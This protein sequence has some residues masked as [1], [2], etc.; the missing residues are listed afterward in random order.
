MQ[1]SLPPL[2]LACLAIAPFG[3]ASA[4]AQ[5]PDNEPIVLDPVL[6]NA[7]RITQLGSEN[8]S[9]NDFRLNPSNPKNRANLDLS[10]TLEDYSSYSSYRRTRSYTAHPTTQGVRIRN[11]GATATSRALVLYDGVPQNDPFGGW[12]YWHQYNTAQ[13]G[14]VLFSPNGSGASWGNL[15]A[16]GLVSIISNNPLHGSSTVDFSV[17][18]S[19]T[20]ILNATST[21]AINETSLIDLQ[22]R[23][24]SSDGFYTLREDQRGTVDQRASSDGYALSTRL[25]LAPTEDWNVQLSAKAFSEERGNGTAV[26]QNET[27]A[28]NLSL[29]AEHSID[30]DSRLNIA[31]Y[32]QDRDFQNVFAAVAAERNSERP[33]LDQYDVPANAYGGAI[34]YTKQFDENSDYSVG[35]DYRAT[36]GSVNERYRNLGAGFSRHRHAGGKQ[37]FAGAFAKVAT[38]FGNADYLSA[39]VRVDKVKNHNATRVET[40]TDTGATLRSDN[41]ANRSDTPFSANI[42]WRHVFSGTTSSSLNLFTGFRAPT[43]NELYRPF[44]VRNDITEANP[45]LEN[46]Q[47]KGIELSLLNEDHDLYR[48][49]AS[50]FHTQIEDMVANVLITTASG[51]D[52]RFGFIPGGGSGS[53]RLNL[54]KTTVSGF[55]LQSRFY[56]SET[57]TLDSSFTYSDTN[58]DRNTDHPQFVGNQFPQ[59]SPLRVRA[60]IEWQAS[61]DFLF[62][63][64]FTWNDNAYDDLGNNRRIGKSSVVSLGAQYALNEAQSIGLVIENLFDEETQSGRATNGL[65]TIDSPREARL[66]WSWR[67]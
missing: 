9:A 39:S 14:D 41:Y 33:A 13:I 66:I 6:V 67:K 58:V 47:V 16:G 57:L 55:E 62:W 24:F 17:G 12:L 40:N 53:Q 19:D 59:S 21:Q 48:I 30:S 22:F 65:I 34:T 26:T 52:P 51:F 25:R 50:I 32:H 46:E 10:E 45:L 4:Q 43:L 42:N 31:I 15:G 36:T 23:G 35:I 56:V 60:S 64:D 63:S 37:D 44:R 1:I 61:E 27:D 38:G 5:T 7:S 3:T 2:L 18:T 54:D 11:L 49:N 28:L 29:I 8:I 20:Y